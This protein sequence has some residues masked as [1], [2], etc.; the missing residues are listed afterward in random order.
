MLYAPEEGI[1]ENNLNNSSL[2]NKN[3][4]SNLNKEV[5][6]YSQVII[7]IVYRLIM[8]IEC[9]DSL[10]LKFGLVDYLA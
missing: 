3:S 4:Q 1:V 2:N 6:V 5:M 10:Y 8:I 9:Y 7:E